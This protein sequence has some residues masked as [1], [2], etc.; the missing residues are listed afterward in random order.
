MGCATPTIGTAEAGDGHGQ[1]RQPRGERAFPLSGKNEGAA[2][3]AALGQLIDMPTHRLAAPH[4]TGDARVQAARSIRRAAIEIAAGLQPT[5]APADRKLDR[6]GRL[7]KIDHQDI[8]AGESGNVSGCLN[9][10]WTAASQGQRSED[11]VAPPLR[12]SSI[13]NSRSAAFRAIKMPCAGRPRQAV[14][15]ATHCKIS[16]MALLAARLRRHFLS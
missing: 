14:S 2:H 8:G 11:G 1:V 9:E 4:V 6:L 5:C 7:G 12:L 3:A 10:P 16:P 15:C 13:Q